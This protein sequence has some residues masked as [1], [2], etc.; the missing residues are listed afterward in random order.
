V[1]R[2]TFLTLSASASMFQTLTCLSVPPVTMQPRMC[3]LMSSAE[4]AP[5]CACSVKRV[6]HGEDANAVDDGN[7]R[8][9]KLTTMPFSSDT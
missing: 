6:G 4:T 9:S 2:L 3:G 8:A 1:T 7:A 5:S